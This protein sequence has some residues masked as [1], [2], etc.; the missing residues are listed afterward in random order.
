ML[1]IRAPRIELGTYCVLGS[2]H[3]Q[4][5]QARI[6][7]TYTY[8]S[9]IYIRKYFEYTRVSKYWKREHTTLFKY[10]FYMRITYEKNIFMRII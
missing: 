2:R 10:L 7:Y 5:D 3:N 9:N 1:M 8:V 4:L 6:F